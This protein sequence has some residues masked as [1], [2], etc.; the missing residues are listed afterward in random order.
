MNDDKDKN[1]EKSFEFNI[2]VDQDEVRKKAS[3]TVQLIEDAMK[4]LSEN[5]FALGAVIHASQIMQE[6]GDVCPGCA[7]HAAD[8]VLQKERPALM[9][10]IKEELD[11]MADEE[12][13]C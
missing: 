6:V 3:E 12:Q 4:F 10:K 2:K 1:E 8:T 13:V 5:G 9:Q 7:L 11:R